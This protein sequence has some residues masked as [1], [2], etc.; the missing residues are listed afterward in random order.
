VARNANWGWLRD[1]CCGDTYG[2]T[3]RSD[4]SNVAPLLLSFSGFVCLYSMANVRCL[5][6]GVD[7]LLRYDLWNVGAAVGSSNASGSGGNFGM[8]SVSHALPAYAPGYVVGPTAA[9]NPVHAQQGA[10]GYG[11]GV[12]GSAAGPMGPQFYPNQ[13]HV[14][15]SNGSHE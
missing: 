15:G 6:L 7:P 12:V 8:G 5:R 9:L 3:I 4:V 13:Q 2:R 1:A 14:V 11:W 10:Y